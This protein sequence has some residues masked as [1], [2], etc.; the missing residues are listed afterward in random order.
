MSRK[1]LRNSVLETFSCSQPDSLLWDDDEILC[2]MRLFFLFY[3][4]LCVPAASS[5][6]DAHRSW[7]RVFPFHRLYMREEQN[8]PVVCVCVYIIGFSFSHYPSAHSYSKVPHGICSVLVFICLCLC[9][10]LHRSIWGQGPGQKGHWSSAWWWL[11]SCKLSLALS[12]SQLMLLKSDAL[13]GSITNTITTQPS[14]S[15]ACGVIWMNWMNVSRTTSDYDEML[16]HYWCVN[17]MHYVYGGGYSSDFFIS[18]CIFFQSCLSSNPVSFQDPITHVLFVL[19]FFQD[20]M[21]HVM[22]VLFF[23]SGLHCLE[24]VRTV[25]QVKPCWKHSCYWPCTE[26]PPWI[27]VGSMPMIITWG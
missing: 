13:W 24:V 25:C 2:K 12:L 16:E 21:T 4:F 27:N 3:V 1:T 23:F 20:P 26:T 10:L 9:T 19:F 5:A 6:A 15:H 8:R 22:F 18:G 17:M 14:Q 7:A 11:G